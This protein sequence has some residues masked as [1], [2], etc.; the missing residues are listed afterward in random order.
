MSK[1]ARA[2]AWN[3]K[4]GK[5]GKNFP[6]FSIFRFNSSGWGAALYVISAVDRLP[7]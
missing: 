7:H 6:F 2:G 3:R 1:S 4:T 5:A